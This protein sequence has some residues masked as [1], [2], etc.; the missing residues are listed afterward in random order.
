MKKW[1]MPEVKELEISNTE[2][3]GHGY[4]H[5]KGHGKG[6]HKG[7][8]NGWGCPDVKPDFGFES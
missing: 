6:H 8:D 3:N 2:R 7:H 5:D 4:G 1:E